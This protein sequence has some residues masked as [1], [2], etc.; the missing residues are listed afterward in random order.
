M[1]DP[2][3]GRPS[4]AAP[5]LY[6]KRTWTG[7]ARPGGLPGR[8]EWQKMKIK[9]LL[10]SIWRQPSWD[11]SL[12]NKAG[13]GTN[14]VVGVSRN[15][16]VA[17]PPASGAFVTGPGARGRLRPRPPSTAEKCGSAGGAALMTSSVR[18]VRPCAMLWAVLRPR[19]SKP[20]EAYAREGGRPPIMASE[21]CITD[22]NSTRFLKMD[23]ISGE[24]L[25]SVEEHIS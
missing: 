18:R 15:N 4:V 22:S 17:L 6:A 16:G 25:R 9:N 11:R 24:V 1:P 23:E 19:H 14:R 8:D 7:Q 12:T 3:F 13:T 5:H 2:S 10:S 20:R 21:S